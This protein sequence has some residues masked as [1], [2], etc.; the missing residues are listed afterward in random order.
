MTFNDAVL[1]AL[2]DTGE[3]LASHQIFEHPACEG[4]TR[5]QVSSAVGHLRQAGKIRETWAPVP[6]PPH[7]PKQVRQYEI[8]P[9]EDGLDAALI[10]ALALSATPEAATPTAAAQ[11]E[12]SRHAAARAPRP[13]RVIPRTGQPSK[14]A[15]GHPF[16]RPISTKAPA[17]RHGRITRDLPG[18][19]TTPAADP[20]PP[21]ARLDAGPALHLDPLTAGPDPDGATQ[22]AQYISAAAWAEAE[23]EATTTTAATTAADLA[24]LGTDAL[25]IHTALD[26]DLACELATATRPGASVTPTEDTLIATKTH[27][28]CGQCLGPDQGKSAL[29]AGHGDPCAIHADT[30][31]DDAWNAYDAAM[32]DIKTDT[33]GET[34]PGAP[35]D[36]RD[37]W[38]GIEPGQNLDPN[39][40]VKPAGCMTGEPAGN[41]LATHDAPPAAPPSPPPAAPPA[42]VADLQA[43]LGPLPVDMSL[44]QIGARFMMNIGPGELRLKTNDD[45]GGPFIRLNAH[46]LA[47]NSGELSQLD[48]YTSA[49]IWIYDAIQANAHLLEHPINR[50]A[51]LDQPDA[52]GGRDPFDD[53]LAPRTDGASLPW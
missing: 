46:S 10:A 14:P 29:Y 12:Q 34:A 28:C 26:A 47:L 31:G 1:I 15:A 51:G 41:L 35:G 8:M 33:D 42:W 37:P 22:E 21:A 40:H 36:Q 52:K 53:L 16:T 13:E 45:G 44:Y 2:R 48:R 3:P 20:P 11:A 4:M 6:G 38:T 23:A 39:A 25:L 19:L 50:P 30:A 43:W 27:D 18:H 5:Q 32:K 24:A 7:G 17:D 49:L 9:Q